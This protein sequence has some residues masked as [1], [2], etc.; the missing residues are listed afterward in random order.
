MNP[1]D[2]FCV[3][4]FSLH[5]MSTKSRAWL[6]GAAVG[7]AAIAVINHRFIEQNQKEMLFSLRKAIAP[8]G[9][10]ESLLMEAKTSSNSNIPFFS[11]ET[12]NLVLIFISD[13]FIFKDSSE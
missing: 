2:C 9:H 5:S 4:P 12:M 7:S 8:P 13:R 10:I 3:H 6:F 1:V 11:R